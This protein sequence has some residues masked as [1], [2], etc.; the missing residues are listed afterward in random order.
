MGNFSDTIGGEY[1]VKNNDLWEIPGFDGLYLINA[2]GRVYR[3]WVK[4]VWK[5]SGFSRRVYFREL[6]P[7]LI[8]NKYLAVNLSVN[9]TAKRGYIKTLLKESIHNE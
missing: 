6:K 7:F 1:S 8:E 3:R 9:G 4:G 5:R 2:E